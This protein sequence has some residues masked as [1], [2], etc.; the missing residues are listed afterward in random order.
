MLVSESLEDL[1]RNKR[2][3]INLD[4]VDLAYHWLTEGKLL[5][6]CYGDLGDESAKYALKRGIMPPLPPTNYLLGHNNW[7][8]KEGQVCFT[9][10]PTYVDPVFNEDSPCLVFD[11]KK[12]SADYEYLDLTHNGE[13]EFRMYNIKDWPKYL[14]QIDIAKK[15]YLKG[16]GWEQ[17]R[18][19]PI[20][21]WLPEELKPKVHTF[22]TLKQLVKERTMN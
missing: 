3:K 17:Y 9:V 21:D 20:Q 16:T 1:L 5:D 10:D 2:S 11:F 15:N 6:S 19:R 12:L 4:N 22:S 7:D 14:V 13:A 18:F 8:G